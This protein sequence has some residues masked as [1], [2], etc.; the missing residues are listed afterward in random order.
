MVCFDAVTFTVFLP[1]LVIGS[2]AFGYLMGR[3]Q[4]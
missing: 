1:V 3:M 2:W 4:P